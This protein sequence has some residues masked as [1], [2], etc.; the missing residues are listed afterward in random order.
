MVDL[1]HCF[2]GQ[3]KVGA[4]VQ[5]IAWRQSFFVG[6]QSVGEFRVWFE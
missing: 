4:S 6:L 1:G 3:A 5:Q 2:L